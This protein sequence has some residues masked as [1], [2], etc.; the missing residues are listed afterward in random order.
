[1]SKIESAARRLTV[2]LTA[3]ALAVGATLLVAASAQAAP[4][5]E[6]DTV[7]YDYCVGAQL[8]PGTGPNATDRT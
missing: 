4:A 6:P 2:S 3:A 7:N 5:A 8:I 1:M